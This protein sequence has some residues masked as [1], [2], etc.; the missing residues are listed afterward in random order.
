MRQAY[1]RLARH[2]TDPF[3]CGDAAVADGGASTGS[4]DADVSD[5]ASIGGDDEGDDS[6]E[7]DDGPYTPASE[8]TDPEPTLFDDDELARRFERSL[9]FA[10]IRRM[11]E[12][13][14]VEA[15]DNANGV[16]RS[17][18]RLSYILDGAGERADSLE[19]MLRIV[20]A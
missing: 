10:G 17:C 19:A 1:D 2:A 20:E 3:A 18:R 14:V 13:D 8:D 4:A 7:Q 11:D 5:C 16:P 12:A 9:A 6:G 15:E